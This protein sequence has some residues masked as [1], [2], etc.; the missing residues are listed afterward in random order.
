MSDY[1][2]EKVIRYPIEE[3]MLEAYNANDLE[4]LIEILEDKSPEFKDSPE[5]GFFTMEYSDNYIGYLDYVLNYE[6]GACEGDFGISKPLNSVQQL[7]WNLMFSRFVPNIDSSKFRLVRFCYYN[8]VDCPE[9]Y[10]VTP[11]TTDNEEW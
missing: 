10:D 5:K 3:E 7:K 2:R 4:E 1:V 6:Y 11:E 8:G 9:Y